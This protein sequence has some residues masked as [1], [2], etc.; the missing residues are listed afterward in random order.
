MTDEKRTDAKIDRLLSGQSKL[1]GEVAGLAAIVSGLSARVSGLEKEVAARPC[2]VHAIQIRKLFANG[3]R[4]KEWTAV[5]R[6][7]RE[8]LKTIGRVSVGVFAIL[9]AVSAVAGALFMLLK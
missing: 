5:A 2:S 8:M 3:E 6:G 4:T 7:R 9:G 1:V